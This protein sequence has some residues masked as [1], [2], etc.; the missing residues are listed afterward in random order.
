MPVKASR[1]GNFEN[2]TSSTIPCL[3]NSAELFVT[4]STTFL[5]YLVPGTSLTLSR[6]LVSN[7]SNSNGYAR[8]G[9]GGGYSRCKAYGGVPL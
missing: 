5:V 9:G 3:T 7:I 6:A 4:Y 8:G 2:K 1:N